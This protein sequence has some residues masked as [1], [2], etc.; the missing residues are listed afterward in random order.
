MQTV[1][2]HSLLCQPPHVCQL[3]CW[4][5][6]CWHKCFSI[7]PIFVIF[8]CL[9]PINIKFHS[10]RVHTASELCFNKHVG[11]SW[12]VAKFCRLHS[13]IRDTDKKKKILHQIT[14]KIKTGE[15]KMVCELNGE[16]SLP[17]YPFYRIKW[18][19]QNSFSL[20][21]QLSQQTVFVVPANPETKESWKKLG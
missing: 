15:I 16:S 11:D 21:L 2:C 1:F 14:W 4:C 8:K 3:S 7:L 18:S 12:S 20:Q 6:S 10:S 17:S 13:S 19:Y 5:I 9:S